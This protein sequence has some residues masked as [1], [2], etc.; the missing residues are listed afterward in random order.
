MSAAPTKSQESK[1]Q[2]RSV[3]DEPPVNQSESEAI[4]QTATDYCE[5]IMEYGSDEL[6]ILIVKKL[7]ER[8]P[9]VKALLIKPS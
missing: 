1:S 9:A 3:W 5:Q 8:C 2:N 4:E 6:S 7:A